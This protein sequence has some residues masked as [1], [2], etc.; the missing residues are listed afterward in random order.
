VFWILSFFDFG[1]HIETDFS[2]P[3]LSANLENH[4]PKMVAM[5][6]MPKVLIG[7]SLIIHLIPKSNN[8]RHTDP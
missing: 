5:E 2:S 7:C 3:I 8:H 4:F 6:K 1:S